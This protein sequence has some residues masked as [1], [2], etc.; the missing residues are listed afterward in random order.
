M[1]QRQGAADHDGGIHL[2]GHDDMGAHGGCGGLAVGA[3][4]AKGVL[5]VGHECAP[6]LSPLVDGD[7]CGVSG[8]DLGVV[9]VDGS[10]ADHQILALHIFGKVT[11]D[12][13]DA[14]SAQVLHRLALLHIGAGDDDAHA[15][16]HFG[17]R[18]HGHA[19]NAH[20]MG[21]AAGLQP[22]F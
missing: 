15:V 19:A 5:V 8:G 2:G 22:A 17:Q 10:G 16:Q 1:E 3:G 12:D 13:L 21:A 14:Q 6:G 20:Q 9:V 4:D 7:V 18:G 11:D